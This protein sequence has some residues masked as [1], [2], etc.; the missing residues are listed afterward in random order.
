MS[1]MLRLGL[2][3]TKFAA[4]LRS[5]D[6]ERFDP[7]KLGKEPAIRIVPPKSSEDEE[8]EEKRN[9]KIEVSE[10]VTKSFPEFG[11]GTPEDLI[12]LI[13]RHEALLEDLSLE[14]NYRDYSIQ[15]TVQLP[16]PLQQSPPRPRGGSRRRSRSRD[17]RSR[18][19]DRGVAATAAA[20]ARTSMKE[21]DGGN[22][23]AGKVVRVIF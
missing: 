1:A 16:S 10:G 2:L 22:E 12:K 9:V 21:N 15:L 18:S 4:S 20:A 23:D 17:N 8:G 3:R 11:G 5:K 7:S 19:A 6:M 14:Q 13:K